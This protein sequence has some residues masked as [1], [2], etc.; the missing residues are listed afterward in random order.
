MSA[1]VNRLGKHYDQ[2]L[3]TIYHAAVEPEEWQSLLQKLVTLLDGCSAFMLFLDSPARSLRASHVVNLD[4]V[5][6]RRYT[7]YYMNISPWRP[8]L[9]YKPSGRLYSTYLDFS[10]DQH[11][12]HRSEFYS[13]WA[14][15][16]G[17]EHGLGGNVAATPEYTV[18]LLVQRST[19]PGHFTRDETVAVNRLLPHMRHALALQRRFE[20]EEKYREGLA[21]SKGL[22]WLPCVLLDKRLEVVHVD[23]GVASLL[24]AHPELRISQ[25]KISLRDARLNEQLQRCLK[26]CAAA[27]FGEWWHVGESFFLHDAGGHLEF[28]TYPIHP[29]SQCL[30]STGGSYVAIYLKAPNARYTLTERLVKESFSLSPTELRLAEAICNGQTLEEFAA[31]NGTSLNTVRSQLKQL[32]AKIGASRQAEVPIRLLPYMLMR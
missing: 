17:I 9:R 11:Y 29:A 26:R 30:F 19:G 21:L 28:H 24:S 31:K 13:D 3:E 12:F 20:E 5:Y 14:K 2:L 15:P 6:Y 32:F 4:A 16:L 1:V 23:E 25:K 8:E 7:D 18:Q 22:S 10:H 27:A